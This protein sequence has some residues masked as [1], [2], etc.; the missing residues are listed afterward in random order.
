VDKIT[1]L[2]GSVAVGNSGATLDTTRQVEFEG[3]K[4]AE[5]RQAGTNKG[6]VTDSRGAIETLYR[7][8]DGRLLVHIKDWSHWV[9]EPTTFS[10][11]VVSEDDLR[12]AGRFAVLGA[13]AGMGRPLTLDE[14]LDL[15][16]ELPED[17][18]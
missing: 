14:A 4:L 13:E 17:M 8:D 7:A 12:G 6:Q 9:S 10:L 5:L 2:I 15:G 1:V 18:E 16:V 11:Q 3:E